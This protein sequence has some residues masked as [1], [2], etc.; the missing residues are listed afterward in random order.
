MKK[1]TQKSSPNHV[2]QPDYTA[3]KRSTKIEE[4]LILIL[5]RNE[6]NTFDANR[7]YGDSCLHSEISGIQKDYGILIDRVKK[8]VLTARSNSLFAHYF[9]VGDNRIKAIALLDR[10]RSKRNAQPMN[11]EGVE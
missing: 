4:C 7:A 2:S 5:K 3:T 8:Q 9:L 6:T 1:A 11:W 10:L